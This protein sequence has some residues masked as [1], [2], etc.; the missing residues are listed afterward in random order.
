MNQNE[1]FI[2]HREVVIFHDEVLGRGQISTVYKG[3]WRFIDVAVKK[4]NPGCR[5][6]DRAYM[7]KELDILV[8]MH[9]P[10]IVQV[11]GVCWNP[12][13]VIL[14]Y[15]PGGNLRE[16]MVLS[17]HLPSCLTYF[18]KKKWSIQLCIALLYLHERKP[19]Y[20][21]HRDIKPTNILMDRYGNLKLSDFG[22][23]KLME[24][25]VLSSFPSIESDMAATAT[26]AASAEHPSISMTNQVGTLYYM[27]PEVMNPSSKKYD[28]RADLWGLGC[29]LYEV[30]ENVYLR[31]TCS[32]EDMYSGS[33]KPRFLYTPWTLRPIILACL[34]QN[35]DHRPEARVVLDI[36]YQL[37][38]MW[39][40]F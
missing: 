40:C 18:K 39:C 12:F 6:Q 37:P 38:T 7:N 25:S 20:V 26:A 34:E 8:K 23:S 19:E 28:T 4:F 5:P 11:L 36:L 2:D 21:I 27:A 15:M 30:W 17:Q 32:A 13:M 10:H 24:V 3:K 9:H 1:W 29:T 31:N 35:P 14:E 33:W 22:I 16:S